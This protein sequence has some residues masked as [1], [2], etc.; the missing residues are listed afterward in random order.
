MRRFNWDVE[1]VLD[2]T[3]ER[4]ARF[5]ET[6]QN[7]PGVRYLSI[8]TARPM[9]EMPAWAIPSWLIVQKTEGPNDGLVSVTSAK[10]AHHLG[11]WPI[12]HW[13]AVNR[14]LSRTAIKAGDISPRYLTLLQRI[15]RIAQDAEGIS[16]R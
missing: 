6:I 13:H 8:S 16:H 9:K 3:T 7:V 10:W 11:T 4:C 2:L 12:D 5:N 1:A 15:A 14:R